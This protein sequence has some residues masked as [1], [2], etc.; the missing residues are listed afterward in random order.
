MHH[1]AHFCSKLVY[2][3]LCVLI[4]CILGL[5]I[6]S[7]PNDAIASSE[8]ELF[9]NSLACSGW[10]WIRYQSFALLT[11]VWKFTVASYPIKP[12]SCD[13]DHDGWMSSYHALVVSGTIGTVS[14]VKSQNLWPK[15]HDDVIKWKHFPRYWPFVRGIH[16]SP[17]NSPHKGQWRGALMSSLICAWINDWVN[18]GK[19]G[20]LRRH[21]AHYDVTVMEENVQS[22]SQSSTPIFLLS[23]A[24]E[25]PNMQSICGT[26]DGQMRH[27]N[28]SFGVYVIACS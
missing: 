26:N 8:F 14:T 27:W 13:R 1:T 10:Q 7:W 17:V 28:G 6:T 2:R 4:Y 3:G 12:Y 9:F 11:F 21:P 22:E 15:L 23:T 25:F 18:N 19:A 24:G 16:R 5:N 20:D